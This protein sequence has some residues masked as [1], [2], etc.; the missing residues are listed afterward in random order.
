M[1]AGARE[2]G[3][4]DAMLNHEV[5]VAER[6]NSDA[7]EEV[8]WGEIGGDGDGIDLVRVVKLE[9]VSYFMNSCFRY[10]LHEDVKE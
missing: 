2:F 6:G 8:F 4:H 10:P 9:E 5:G 1:G 3:A 7:D